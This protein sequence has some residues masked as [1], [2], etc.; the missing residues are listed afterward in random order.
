MALGWAW[1]IVDILLSGYQCINYSYYHD[2]D[3][4]TF[5]IFDK[6]SKN[7]PSTGRKHYSI[8]SNCT[9]LVPRSPPCTTMTN[10]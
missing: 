6:D 7:D 2:S 5:V 3:H 8:A 9:S 4:L 10:S 1:G